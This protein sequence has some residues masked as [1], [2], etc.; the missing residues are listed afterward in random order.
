[1]RWRSED[2]TAYGTSITSFSQ[3]STLPTEE[4]TR[5][6]TPFQSLDTSIVSDNIPTFFIGRNKE[7][8]WVARDVKG[9]IGGIF[10]FES[11]ALSFA[12][13]KS[14]RTGCATIYQ[15]ETFELD[16]KNRGNPFIAYLA[17]KPA[18]R[19]SRSLKHAERMR[20]QF[21]GKRILLS[22]Q[23]RGQNDYSGTDSLHDVRIRNCS[24]SAGS[25]KAVQSGYGLHEIQPADLGAYQDLLLRLR[26]IGRGNHGKNV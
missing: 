22:F 1:M 23:Q 8:F 25:L 16:L 6:T 5:F 19:S 26:R 4:P 24:R 10:L 11:S 13:R 21:T 9:K 17:P 18:E 20:K 3:P 2:S 14:R 7:G 15:S 12:R